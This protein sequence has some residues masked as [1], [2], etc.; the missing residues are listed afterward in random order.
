MIDSHCHLDLDAFDHDRQQVI[1]R[2]NRA[3]VTR[4]HIPGTEYCRWPRLLEL[5]QA[6]SIDVSLGLHPYF[7]AKHS[8]SDLLLQL[9]E[10]AKLLKTQKS[11]VF[12]VGECGLDAV[13]DVD[14][15]LQKEVFSRQITLAQAHGLPLIVHARKSHHHIIQCLNDCE[16]SGRGIIHAFSG[17]VELAKQYT[18]RGWLLGIGGTIT[19]PRGE[20]TRKTLQ[21]IGIE[22]LVLETDAPDMP[23]FGLQGQRNT[24][25]NI[26]KIAEVL[27]QTLGLTLNEVATQTSKNYL[28]LAQ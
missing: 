23:L 9:E 14:F 10:L 15:Q 19:Y 17:S 26:P 2:A 4:I 18:E 6:D 21:Q 11:H 5:A 8:K 12:A 16:F 7:L 3:D 28:S 13:I 1:E 27:A 24:P 20:K 25:A 22:H